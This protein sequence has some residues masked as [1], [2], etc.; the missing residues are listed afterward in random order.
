MKAA[1]VLGLIVSCF[2][3]WHTLKFIW[4]CITFKNKSDDKKDK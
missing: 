2:L 3:V 1:L 4:F